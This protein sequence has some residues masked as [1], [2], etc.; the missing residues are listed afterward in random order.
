M[1]FSLNNLAKTQSLLFII[2]F[3]PKNHVRRR[4]LFPHFL[5][6][7]AIHHGLCQFHTFS[8]FRIIQG[9]GEALFLLALASKRQLLTMP[10][11]FFILTKNNPPDQLSVIKSQIVCQF[12]QSKIGIEVQPFF[13]AFSK[14]Q[15]KRPGGCPRNYFLPREAPHLG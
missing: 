14:S 1:N 2:Y 8:K 9:L 11:P 6:S 3:G 4:Q 15:S 7:N 5:P 12:K 10:F 13:F